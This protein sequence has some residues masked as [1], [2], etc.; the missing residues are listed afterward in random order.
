M[1]VS[2][3]KSKGIGGLAAAGADLQQAEETVALGAQGRMRN[4]Q[5]LTGNDQAAG[6]DLAPDRT[7]QFRVR[8]RG[9][10]LVPEGSSCSEA[11]CELL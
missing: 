10:G 9:P 6:A 8:D 11:Q 3:A 1:A 2:Q 7:Q 4:G 5:L